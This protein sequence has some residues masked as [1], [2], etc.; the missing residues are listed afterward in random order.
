MNTIVKLEDFDLD[1]IL[2]DDLTRF[3]NKTDEFIRTYD[4]TRHLALFGSEKD[5]GFYNKTRCL[6]KLKSGIPYIIS[7]YY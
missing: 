7:V 6:I 1:N 3:D 2:I 4:G 5:D